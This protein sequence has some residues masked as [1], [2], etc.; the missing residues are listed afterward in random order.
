MRM[1]EKLNQAR[2]DLNRGLPDLQPD[3]LTSA[4]SSHAENEE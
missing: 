2:G 4:P 3:V 1:I